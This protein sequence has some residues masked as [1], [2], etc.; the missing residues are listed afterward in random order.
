MLPDS[1]DLC[2]AKAQLELCKGTNTLHLGRVVSVPFDEKRDILWVPEA[3]SYHPNALTV[4]AKAGHDGEIL[5]EETYYS[6]G[7]GFVQSQ[8]EVD[9]GPRP[10]DVEVDGSEGKVKPF[11]FTCADD[12]LRICKEEGMSFSEIALHNEQMLYGKSKEEVYQG[13]DEIW[14]VMSSCIHNGLNSTE[15]TLPGKLN[16]KRRAPKLRRQVRRHEDI[17]PVGPCLWIDLIVEL[18]VSMRSVWF[19]E[20]GYGDTCLYLPVQ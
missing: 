10:V 13:L 20:C 14:Q 5:M 12:L 15:E 8:A 7:G 2:E 3:K 18:F 1:I 6:I 19:A 16:V 17:G 11:E 4:R 9:A